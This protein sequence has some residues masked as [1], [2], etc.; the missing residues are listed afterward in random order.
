MLAFVI[1]ISLVTAVLSRIY[2][3]PVKLGSRK[4][5]QKNKQRKTS[6]PGINH[7]VCLGPSGKRACLQLGLLEQKVG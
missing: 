7:R 4:G 5:K 3:S 2:K 1:H 6:C